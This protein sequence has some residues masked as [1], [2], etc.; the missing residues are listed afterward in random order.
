MAGVAEETAKVASGVVDAMRNQPLAIANI[1]LNMCFLVF[2]FYYVSR[3]S[4]RAEG[5]VK[6]LFVAQDALY[7]QWGVIIKDTNE[8]TEK[9]M[10]CIYPDDA[11]KLLQAPRQAAPVAPPMEMPPRAQG[12]KLPPLPPLPFK[13]IE[14]HQ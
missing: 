2:L 1:V 13:M 10:H 3:I 9:S 12:L 5:T 14:V 8:L 11:I 6:E 4:T 7:K